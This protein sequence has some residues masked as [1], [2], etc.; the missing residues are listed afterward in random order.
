MDT[1]AFSPANRQLPGDRDG[2]MMAIADP[3]GR[4]ALQIAPRAGENASYAEPS[5]HVPTTSSESGLL[6]A[7]RQPQQPKPPAQ[8][9]PAQEQELVA[10][11]TLL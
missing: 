2:A 5:L 3:S 10:W 7:L 1:Q 4:R 6:T 8:M 11:N 9:S